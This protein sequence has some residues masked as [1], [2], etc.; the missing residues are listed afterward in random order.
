LRIGG[1]REC[2]PGGSQDGVDRDKGLRETKPNTEK[3]KGLL[4]AASKLTQKKK[5]WE[6]RIGQEEKKGE[7]W[8]GFWKTGVEKK[9][10]V[11]GK[12]RRK[13]SPGDSAS[14][15]QNKKR[16]TGW[17]DSPE[18]EE[19]THNIRKKKP[20]MSAPRGEKRSGEG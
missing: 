18:K 13:T 2:K 6:S 17:R 20:P 9:N 1:D 16:E 5:N 4:K 19:V 7:K 8:A 15:V 3:N 12:N 10:I 14:T 11:P